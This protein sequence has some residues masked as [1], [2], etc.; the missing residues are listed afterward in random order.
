[1][2]RVVWKERRA[3]GRLRGALV[4]S[5]FLRQPRKNGRK[6]R[7]GERNREYE[8]QEFNGIKE[9]IRGGREED[10][11]RKTAPVPDAVMMEIGERRMLFVE[12]RE[13][14]VEG[15]E[16]LKKMDVQRCKSSHLMEAW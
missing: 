11:R 12:D 10:K 4:C 9:Q 8:I 2:G 14:P 3:S 5:H 16:S 13:R 6:M 15:T 1:M 7:D